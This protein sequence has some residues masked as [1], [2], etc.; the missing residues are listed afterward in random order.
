MDKHIGRINLLLSIDD[1]ALARSIRRMRQMINGEMDRCSAAYEPDNAE[2]PDP[3][4]MEHHVSEILARPEDPDTCGK[5]TD[6]IA[7][8]VRCTPEALVSGLDTECFTMTTAQAEQ[9]LEYLTVAKACAAVAEHGLSPLRRADAEKLAGLISSIAIGLPTPSRPGGGSH[10]RHAG[11]VPTAAGPGTMFPAAYLVEEAE[12]R[13]AAE[14]A[15]AEPGS[16]KD[17]ATDDERDAA[18]RN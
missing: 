2:D 9:V 6:K 17:T 15:E 16:L 7:A 13:A 3:T 5:L 1:A 14:R 12:R 11:P 10:T 18:A 4:Y 8:A